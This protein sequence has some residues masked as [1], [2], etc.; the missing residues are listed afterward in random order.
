MLLFDTLSK[1]KKELPQKELRLF[2]CGPTVYDFS[3]I[4]H[5]RTYVIF[6]MFVK[7]L[8]KRGYSVDYLQNITDLDDKI[9]GR[10]NENKEVPGEL[11]K[12][13]EKE[14]YADMEALDVSGVTAYKRATD[15]MP[16]IISQV[17]RL[18]EKE[19]AYEIKKDGIY[20]DISKFKNY[21]KLSGRTALQAQ[22]AT[23][24]IDKSVEKRN[25][26]DFALWKF[27]KP[28]EPKAA[29]AK[30]FVEPRWESPWGEGRP[31]WHIEDTAITEKYFGSQYDIHGGGRDLIF[32]HH[33]AEIAQMESISGKE[34]LVEFWM[35]PGFLV[36]NGEKMSKSLNNFVTIR[37]AL[38]NYSPQTLRLFF[39]TKHYRSPI[40]WTP[41]SLV[42]SVSN[43]NKL[44]DFWLS[45]QNVKEDN[46]AEE[47]KEIEKRIK[48]FWGFLEDDF[49]T[50][51]AFAE[52]FGLMNFVHKTNSLSASDKN[53][54]SEFL[55]DINAVFNVVNEENL[56]AAVNITPEILKLADEREKM[57]QEKNW[58]RA[59][60]LRKKIE[61]KGYEIK[62]TEN[63]PQ[64]RKR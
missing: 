38:K 22:D 30:G 21:G 17:K 58:E 19:C 51:R 20:F 1:N 59:D 28:D 18:I 57:R 33:E 16:E 61:E 4:G 3:H 10:A 35:H 40:D 55:K 62:D 13:F 9:I 44:K 42:E 27:S 64:I 29:S 54:T 11:A 2:V 41:D 48:N 52:L 53:K 31:G 39:T 37:D 43:E 12:R 56:S 47:E 49:N 32:P 5:A 26:G 23:S 63:G 46:S 7:Y 8:R 36:V 45:V 60:E 14:Y 15:H 34:P 6:D 24:R 50:P 25:K